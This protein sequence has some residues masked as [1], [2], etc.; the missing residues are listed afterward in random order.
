MKLVKALIAFP[1]DGTERK[2]GDTFG[3]DNDRADR[4]AARGLASIVDDDYTQEK[5]PQYK[6]VFAARAAQGLGAE[7]A[8]IPGIDADTLPPL[9]QRSS[10]GKGAKSAGRNRG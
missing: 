8:P 4:C 3:L 10:R 7:S 6:E 5:D 1:L 2:P 9:P